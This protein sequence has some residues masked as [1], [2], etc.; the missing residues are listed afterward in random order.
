MKPKYYIIRFIFFLISIFLI[1][2]LSGC[3]R[4]RI[5]TEP[6]YKAN[7]LRRPGVEHHVPLKGAT[8]VNRNTSITIW[9]DELMDEAS[10]RDNFRVWPV[11]WID[12]IRVIV[13][14][15]NNSDIVYALKSGTGIFKSDDGGESWSW[16][17]KGAVKI[18]LTDLAV[19]HNNS[20]ILYLAAS[21]SGV[22]KSMD[23]G[24]IWQQVITGLPEMNIS[25]VEVD[26]FDDNTVWAVTNSN[27]IYKSEDG[28]SSWNAKN[29]G[30]RTTRPMIDL[31][32][33][34]LNSNTLYA[35]TKG[36]FILKSTNG[37]ESWARL[38]TGLFSFNFITVAI[39]PQDTSL[40][41]AVSDGTGIYRSKDTGANWELIVEGLESLD[42]KSVVLH[43]QDTKK[44][45]ISTADGLFRSLDSGDTW[46][47]AGDIPVEEVVSMMV[48]DS[49]VPERIFAWTNSGIFRSDDLGDSWT[50]KNRLI[51]DDLYI[52]GSFEFETW[53]DTTIVIAQLNSTMMDTTVMFPY[54]IER[55]LNDWIARGRKGE[56][57]VE[58]NPSA[59]KVIFKPSE[60]LLPKIKI[61]VR[62]RGTFEGDKETLRN[63]FGA[64]DIEGNSLET[65]YNY[66][67][68]TA[69][70]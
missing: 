6:D 30:V 43:P 8:E 28:G 24:I 7:D 54:I 21:D 38:R 56:P 48:I 46:I 2:F 19:S 18:A 11:V 10:I 29:N 31:V 50:M 44:V 61:Q 42:V 63:S 55:A 22:Y 14:D 68:T 40:V 17:T 36:D 23:G 34:P 37:G 67:F 16:L 4:D 69:K 65:D 53:K 57:P 41:F 20:N 25:V 9:F 15:P 47:S 26:P 35:A 13:V 62:I 70:Q 60:L 39:H 49:V 27:G 45:V 5:V 66:T 52:S 51:T 64:S 12:S 3:L 1:Y 32:I 59:T 33:N 58:I